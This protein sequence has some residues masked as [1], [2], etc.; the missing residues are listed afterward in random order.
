[1]VVV[2]IGEKKKLKKG[3]MGVVELIIWLLGDEQQL[4]MAMVANAFKE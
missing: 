2:G 3:H 1:M 4:A